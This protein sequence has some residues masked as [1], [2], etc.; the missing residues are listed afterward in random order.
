MT[1]ETMTLPADDLRAVFDIAVGSMD[2]GS[3]FL[4]DAE[5]ET[6]RRVAV[7]IGVD[8]MEATPSIFAAKYHHAFHPYTFKGGAKSSHCSRCFRVED[9][10]LHREVVR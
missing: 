5:V 7:V 10:E 2:F 4:D 6:L 8:P 9:D 1:A 3:G